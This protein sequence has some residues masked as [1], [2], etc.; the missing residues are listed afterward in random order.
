MKF[1][2]FYLYIKSYKKLNI[3]FNVCVKIF[4]YSE[5]RQKIIINKITH[6]YF[7]VFFKLKKLLRKFKFNFVYLQNFSQFPVHLFSMVK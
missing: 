3:Y 4:I 5:K 2:S 7:G 1:V 6:K